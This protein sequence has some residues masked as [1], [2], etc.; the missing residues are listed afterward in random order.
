[1]RK[2]TAQ[3]F[4]G[5]L[6]VLSSS[7]I[8]ISSLEF[9]IQRKKI[10]NINLRISAKNAEIFV[11]A[12]IRTSI[13][14]ISKF[15]SSKIDWIHQ[16][17]HEVRERI[18]SKKELKI[19]YQD[20]D[21][22]YFFGKKYQ[23]RLN[24]IKKLVTEKKSKK[25]GEVEIVEDNLVLNCFSEDDFQKRKTFIE[26]FYRQQLLQKSLE[27]IAKFEL[28][29]KVK[30]N[31]FGV[32]KMRTRYGS[33]NVRKA[34]IWLSLDMAKRSS[35]LIELIIVHEMAH[36]I[37]ANHSKKFYNLMDKFLPD[38]RN[39]DKILRLKNLDFC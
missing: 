36:L 3:I 10:K 19:N 22:L 14:D 30:V 2:K 7:K 35:K 6:P 13:A 26:K 21:N 32:K 4:K 29:I 9:Q 33:C 31:Q 20:N 1:M 23:L 16:K 8:V 27:I 25:R 18:S 38:W 37:E 34:R 12:P 17:Q 39:R 24:F 28:V 11:S 15:L 5:S